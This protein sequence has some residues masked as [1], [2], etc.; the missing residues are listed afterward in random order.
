MSRRRSIRS[1]ASD[2]GHVGKA[3]PTSAVHFCATSDYPDAF[4]QARVRAYGFPGIRQTRWIVGRQQLTVDDVRAGTKFSDAVARTAWPIELHDQVDGHIWEPCERRPRALCA[5]R[6]PRPRRGRQHRRRR[7][8]HRGGPRPHS[9][10]C[11]S[12]GRASRWGPRPRHGAR[13]RR[14]GS[15]HQIDVAALRQR[16][17]DNVD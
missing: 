15:V 7:A 8:L 11:G 16:V 1:A 2:Q 13:S 10:P 9:R 14:R 5:V 4:G 12:W 3:R 17:R 6:Q